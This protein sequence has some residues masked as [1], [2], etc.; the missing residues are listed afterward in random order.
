MSI[1]G[2]VLCNVCLFVRDRYSPPGINYYTH[3]GSRGLTTRFARA[4]FVELTTRDADA[5]LAARSEDFDGRVRLRLRPTHNP[6]RAQFE[7]WPW[8]S[9]MRV[10][11]PVC[12]WV[13]SLRACRNLRSLAREDSAAFWSISGLVLCLE[14]VTVF[15]LA[16]A[17][18]LGAG[19]WSS[20]IVSDQVHWVCF[21]GFQGVALFTSLAMASVRDSIDN[22]EDQRDLK[23]RAVSGFSNNTLID[24]PNQ[25][26]NDRDTSQERKTQTLVVV[27]R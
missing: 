13:T 10:V 9:L 24:R 6:W 25:T 21:S 18:A 19:T 1:G 27:R 8:V 23:R 15:I 4:P 2:A 20:A 22:F 26:G 14:A 12:A 11:L 7:S 3:D 17:L 16:V 5:V